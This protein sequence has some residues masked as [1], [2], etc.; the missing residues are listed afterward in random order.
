MYSANR[1]RA[2]YLTGDDNTCPSPK[3]KSLIGPDVVFNKA[4]LQ[5]SL[6]D[7]G[8]SSSSRIDEKSISRKFIFRIIDAMVVQKM[9][10]PSSGHAEGQ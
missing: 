6:S 8:S 2:E 5:S 7:D 10:L 3:C 4:T 9:L 1:G